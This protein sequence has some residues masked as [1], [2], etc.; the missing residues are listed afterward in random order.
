MSWKR[1][2]N[3]NT[4]AQVMGSTLQPCTGVAM[5]LLSYRTWYE[6][7]RHTQVV[8]PYYRVHGGTPTSSNGGRWRYPKKTCRTH[9][10]PLHLLP[11]TAHPLHHH[12]FFKKQK[13]WPVGYILDGGGCQ[14]SMKIAA[15]SPESWCIC[16]TVHI[17]IWY[18]CSW[19]DLLERS[20]VVR[21]WTLFP[22][23]SILV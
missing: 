11:H 9:S 6:I 10:V 14:K 16:D 21:L 4:S 3:W 7:A 5:E 18:C 22:S 12:C 13:P 23:F 2:R 17:S 19:S 20:Q 15:E 8:M 1:S